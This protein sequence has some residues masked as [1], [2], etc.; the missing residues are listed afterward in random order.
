MMDRDQLLGQFGGHLDTFARFRG[1]IDKA[2]A[3][4]GK[5][6]SAIVEKVC[7]DNEIKSQEV[8]D[9]VRPL[10]P[11]VEAVIATLRGEMREI[12]EGRGA[13][14]ER[15]EELELRL[16]I[17][18]M[19][20]GEFQAASSSLREQ[21]A[22]ADSAIQTRRDEAD[23]FASSLDRWLELAGAAGHDSGATAAA[24]TPAVP[25]PVRVAAP[26][27]QAAQVMEPVPVSAPPDE[28]AGLHTSTVS[29]SDDVSTV[30]AATTTAQ[31][32]VASDE[33]IAIEASEVA[34]DVDLGGVE[35]DLGLE[36]D[37]AD[38]V[39]ID[40]EAAGD[41]GQLGGEDSPRGRR[42]VLLYQEGTAE[43][44]IYPFV[45]DEMTVGRGRD[46]TIQITN[47][48]KVSRNHCR[49]YLKNGNYYMKDN[50]SSNGSLVNGELV[51]ERRLFGGEEIIIGETF[52][53]FRIM[54]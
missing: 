7:L 48:S 32:S 44:R 30:F 22:S 23:R 31:V 37:S 49:I 40:L 51:T 5:F 8:A 46:N 21:L 34:E 4:S 14:R 41:V 1:F 18:E 9:L 24:L 35:V 13:A 52:F 26:V 3:Q 11:Q 25:S 47:D 36:G 50:K 20:D 43:E 19:D 42:A 17:E 33:D 10:V 15:M 2:R 28:N 6:S 53:R 54:D 27:P 12:E 16:A 39:E 38:E 45:G 29:V